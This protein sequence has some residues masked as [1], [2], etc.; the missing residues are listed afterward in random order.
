LLAIHGKLFPHDFSKR[1]VLGCLSAGETPLTFAINSE[2]VDMVPYLLDHGA[3]TEKLNKTVLRLST[4][5][6]DKV[7]VSFSVFLLYVLFCV[8]GI[9]ALL[10]YHMIEVRKGSFSFLPP[11]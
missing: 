2:S 7:L 4:L 10:E 9:K 3:D 11:Q 8:L 6:S 1:H 5:L